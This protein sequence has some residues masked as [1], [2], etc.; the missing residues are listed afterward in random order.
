MVDEKSLASLNQALTGAYKLAVVKA[1]DLVFL[2]KNARYMTSQT[3][4]RLVE[5]I[6][7]DGQLSSVPFCWLKDSKYHVLSG[8]HRLQAAIKA[9]LS[10]FLVLYT[11]AELSESQRVAIQLSHNSI[12]G[13]D[14]LA[15][16]KSLWEDIS[17]LN[18]KL[19]AGLD[20]KTLELLKKVTVKNLSEVK[21]DYQEVYILFLPEEKE[22]LDKA[23]K[24]AS[25]LSEKS[26]KYA[27]RIQ[28]FDRFLSALDRVKKEYKIENRA[29]ALM[30]ILDI[31]DKYKGAES[32][33]SDASA[34]QVD[35]EGA[36]PSQRSK[37]PSSTQ[38]GYNYKW[39]KLRKQVLEEAPNCKDCGS[40]AQEVHHIDGNVKNM[41]RDNLIS[42]C[43]SCHSRR[44]ALETGGLVC[45]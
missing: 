27:A 30:L 3:F 6:K 18:D 29:T 24:E 21:I 1:E 42:L 37:R 20:D 12:E 38:R 26:I 45:Q 33:D 28:D 41:S 10:E 22:R 40:P 5:N 9:G 44:T 39:T 43:T 14:D 36:S 2:K 32:I 23:L 16:L 25:L 35:K 34:D 4:Q 13:K 15:V 8:N 17:D 11:D 31:F 7:Q 19:Y